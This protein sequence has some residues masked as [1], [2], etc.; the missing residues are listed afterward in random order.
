MIRIVIAEDEE[1]VRIRL[2]KYLNNSDR[3][4]VVVGQAEDGEQA[5]TMVQELRPDILMTDI[6]MPQ[7]SGLEM[8]RAVRQTDQ[9][10]PIIVVSGYDEFSYARE[11]M[12]LGV[13]EYLLKPFL[14]KE[15]FEVLD[16]IRSM[17]EQRAKAAAQWQT[18]NDELQKNLR[19]TRQRFFNALLH[20]RLSRQEREATAEIIGFDL[21]ADW[22]CAGLMDAESVDSGK[23]EALWNQQPGMPAMHA[24]PGEPSHTTIFFHGRG[25]DR[26]GVQAQLASALKPLC[27]ALQAQTNAPVRCT[28]GRPCQSCDDLETS[29]K[30]A[31]DTWR[32]C[33]TQDGLVQVYPLDPGPAPGPQ[34]RSKALSEK[35]LLDIQ[36]GD[37]TAALTRLD[38]LMQL[39]A[40]CSPTLASQISMGLLRLV[41]QIAELMRDA[42]EQELAWIEQN[43]IGYLRQHFSTVSLREAQSMLT[44]YIDRCC[45]HFAQRN[46]ADSDKLI[47]RARI[48]IEENLGNE[49][50]DLEILAQ[51]LYFSPTYVRQL[52]KTKMGESFSDYLFRRR[53]ETAGQL[54]RNQALKIQDIAELT[55][56]KDQRYFARCFKKFYRCTPTEYRARS[57]AF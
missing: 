16:K 22:F 15:L 9:E 42:G 40:G 51:N 1:E 44:S 4:Y 34:E 45:D 39:Y 25:P 12:S 29:Y 10:L 6:C 24:V 20:G 2:A 7:L 37:K 46:A 27:L 23:I 13:R 14:P 56:Y 31:L 33:L 48:V 50:F 8:I 47:Y 21:Q 53:M 26:G 38:A 52:F 41:M 30:E 11:A 32:V 28:L 5:L 55:G 54:M 57:D 49:D 19:Y 43:L 36:M 17:L 3:G 35:M 18:M